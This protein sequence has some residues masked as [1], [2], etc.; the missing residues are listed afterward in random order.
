[1]TPCPASSF[2]RRNEIIL[3]ITQKWVMIIGMIAC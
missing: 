3:G 1:M 2:F